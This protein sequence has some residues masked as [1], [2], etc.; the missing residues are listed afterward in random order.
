LVRAANT[1]ISAVVDP[2]GRI[3]D[4]LPLGIEGVLDTRLPAAIEPT[5]AVKYSNYFLGL[6]LVVSLIFVGRRRFR[7]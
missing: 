4:S 6:L 1:G 5:L 3:I 2:V 7:A